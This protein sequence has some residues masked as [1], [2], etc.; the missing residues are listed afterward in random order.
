MWRVWFWLRTSLSLL[1]EGINDYTESG[2]MGETVFLMEIFSL[3]AKVWCLGWRQTTVHW[4]L[5]Y[6]K[7]ETTL[8]NDFWQ[9]SS[10]ELSG[11]C[12]RGYKNGNKPQLF[13][14]RGRSWTDFSSNLCW[15][16]LIN[17]FIN[18]L[19]REAG[20]KIGHFLMIVSVEDSKALCI[21]RGR[22]TKF[23][24]MHKTHEI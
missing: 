8:A 4:L 23:N 13:Y 12:R 10:P 7:N 5:A 17:R 18:D 14:N 21:C 19:D 1:H 22:V 15:N 3:K 9:N 2:A 6:A 16:L 24:L 20:R 11:D